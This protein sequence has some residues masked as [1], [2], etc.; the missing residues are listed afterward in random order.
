MFMKKTILSFA[1]LMGALTM[2]AQQG[3]GLSP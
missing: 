2:T 1:L 3:K